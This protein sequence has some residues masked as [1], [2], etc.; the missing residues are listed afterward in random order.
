MVGIALLHVGTVRLYSFVKHKELT[1]AAAT[2][3]FPAVS[4]Q[5]AEFLLSGV[6]LGSGVLIVDGI[7]GLR[8]KAAVVFGFIGLF[9]V[10][11]LIAGKAVLRRRVLGWALWEKRPEQAT[12]GRSL[13]VPFGVW[14]PSWVRQA[15]G[16][17][18]AGF[19]P[20]YTVLSVLMMGVPLTVALSGAMGSES[21]CG[22]L[23][24]LVVALFII[25]ASV[26]VALRP[27]RRPTD[28]F[29]AAATLPNTECHHSTQSSRRARRRSRIRL[30]PIGL[31]CLPRCVGDHCR[32]HRPNIKNH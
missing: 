13:I 8:D 31:C 14:M 20:Q 7:N 29:F 32:P 27:F 17:T 22:W 2:L 26:V 1:E 10:A 16:P 19:L 3:R 28:T 15:F 30:R 5:I 23:L 4:I 25:A 12:F 6:V 18:F 9:I 21:N 24:W 11:A